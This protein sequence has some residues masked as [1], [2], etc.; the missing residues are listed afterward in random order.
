MKIKF[1]ILVIFLLI[2]CCCQNI[3]AQRK[4]KNT[5]II[6]FLYGA[7]F[8]AE[9]RQEH[10]FSNQIGLY[11]DFKNNSKFSFSTSLFYAQR[12][13]ATSPFRDKIREDAI[14]AELFLKCN[15]KLKWFKFYLGIGYFQRYSLR[16]IGEKYVPDSPFSPFVFSIDEPKINEKKIGGLSGYSFAGGFNWRFSKNI[17]FS[18][19]FGWNSYVS[20]HS[21][22]K[23]LTLLT[24][25]NNFSVRL[26]CGYRISK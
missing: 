5:T 17:I 16:I 22:N 13:F 24:A 18:P 25:V 8:L 9:D 15:L 1:K 14:T 26:R 20:I 23:D 10:R 19:H 12:N 2:V 6:G 11:T 3:F 7:E 4:K 21:R